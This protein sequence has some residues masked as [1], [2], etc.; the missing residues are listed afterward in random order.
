MSQTTLDN[1]WVLIAAALVMV[2]QGGF[3]MLESGL[4]RAK[5]SINVA[6]KNL[7]DACVSMLMF[8]GVGFALMFGASHSGLIGNPGTLAPYFE[9]PRFV[10]FLIFQ[11]VFCTTA[12]TIV[13]GAVAERVKLGS[14][15][16]IGTLL[17]MFLY[18]ISGSWKWGAGWLDGMGFYDFA[19]STLVHAFGGFAAL[20]A[21][22][23]LVGPAIAVSEVAGHR[24]LTAVGERGSEHLPCI[25]ARKLERKQSKRDSRKAGSNQGD[26]LRGE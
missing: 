17:V 16:V 10:T 15:M 24:G 13:S 25:R 11:L 18:P 9:S 12:T 8:F 1:L 19:G 4:V 20:A 7:A 23:V 3:C 5:N 2:M 22:I 26:S 6:M 14:F 21:V